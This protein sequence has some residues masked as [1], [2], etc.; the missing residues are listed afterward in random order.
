MSFSIT[1]QAVGVVRSPFADDNEDRD[2]TEVESEIHVDEALAPGLRGLDRYT[3]IVVTFVLHKFRFDRERD[4][5]Q[6]CLP[7]E[8]A[9]EVGIFALRTYH[10]P[11]AIGTTTV[12]LL[13]VDGNIVRVRGLDALDGSPVLDIKPYAPKIVKRSLPLPDVEPEI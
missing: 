12:K 11:N 13:S 1:L 8:D 6:P 10:R 3:D 4:L 9:E 5:V 7:R 2:W